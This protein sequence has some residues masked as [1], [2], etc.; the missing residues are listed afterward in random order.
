MK[1]FI[2]QEEYFTQILDRFQSNGYKI[3]DQIKQNMP[4]ESFSFICLA[5]KTEYKL[6]RGGFFSTIFV[7]SWYANPGMPDLV[8]YSSHCYKIAKKTTPFLPP[9]G[10]MYG[11]YC[12][13]VVIADELDVETQGNIRQLD[14]PRHWA[15]SEKLVVFNLS[16]SQLY[17]SKKRPFWG[18]LYHQ[19]DEATINYYLGFRT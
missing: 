3:R 4:D 13:P 1:K 17:Y 15:A 5:K 11:F 19:L 10:M 12:F 8:K 9:R 18:S 16:D 6:I 7:I 2:S 14:F